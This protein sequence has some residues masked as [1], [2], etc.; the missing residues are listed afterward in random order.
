MHFR[1]SKKEKAK[2]KCIPRKE[3]VG[4]MSSGETCTLAEVVGTGWSLMDSQWSLHLQKKSSVDGPLFELKGS[5]MVKFFPGR[6]LEYEAKHCE[7]HRSEQN[8]LT[9]VEFSMEDPYGKAVALLDLKSGFFKVKEDWM[10]VPGI[11]SAFI[12]TDIYKKEG[13][14]GFAV[15]CKNLEMDSQTEEVNGFHE[16]KRAKLTTSVASEV[17]RVESGCN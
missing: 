5:R 14:H 13:Y 3:V 1:E 16:G 7:K 17:A 6:K 15:N 2:E 11:T 8:F 9:A 12:L 4:I 10:L